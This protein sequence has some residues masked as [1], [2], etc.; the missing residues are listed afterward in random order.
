[1]AKRCTWSDIPSPNPLGNHNRCPSPHY[2]E[3]KNEVTDKLAV[4]QTRARGIVAD[5]PVRIKKQDCQHE[6]ASEPRQP[7]NNAMLSE[8]G[9]LLWTES[10]SPPTWKGFPSK[11]LT[12]KQLQLAVAV[13]AME[14]P[15]LLLWGRPYQS[16]DR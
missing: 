3:R 6:A 2:A 1:M 15:H 13:L 11:K 7:D 14:Q 10:A 4:H 16:F 9:A 5:A 8:H 12:W